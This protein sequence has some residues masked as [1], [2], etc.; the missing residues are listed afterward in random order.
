TKDI[1]HPYIRIT[2][3]GDRDPNLPLTDIV[4]LMLTF[5]VAPI[6]LRD[7]PKTRLSI[8]S[9]NSTDS[10]DSSNSDRSYTAPPSTPTEFHNSYVPQPAIPIEIYFTG[11]TDYFTY[12][13][14]APSPRGSVAVTPSEPAHAPVDL[15]DDDAPHAPT[16]HDKSDPDAISAMR[17]PAPRSVVIE[18]ESDSEF[19]NMLAEELTKLSELQEESRGVLEDRIERLE[20]EMI[21]ATSPYKS[22]IYTWREII[23]LYADAEILQGYHEADRTTRSVEASRT[24]LALFL[25]QMSKTKLVRR[26]STKQSR[27]AFEQ[28]VLLN[29]NLIDIKQFMVLNRTA[30]TKILKKHDKR[31]GL[32]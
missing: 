29:I 6:P 3:D 28:F 30:I 14:V 4:D 23:K 13:S 19:L 1:L 16:P 22:D 17:D 26:L 9:T 27:A 18:L 10:T 15:R 25:N 24:Q 8:S 11:N 7:P 32:M 2:L 5:P 21:I 12:H 20:K 31:S